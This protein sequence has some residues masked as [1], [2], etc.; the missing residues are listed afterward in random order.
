MSNPRFIYL[1]GF[2][3]SPQSQKASIFKAKFKEM[4]IDLLIPDLETGDF[5]FITIS[6]QMKVIEETIKEVKGGS[7]VVIG[8]SMGGYL[9]ILASQIYSE[10]KGLY[11]M[12]PGLSFLSRWRQ[13]LLGQN[14]K[15]NDFPHLIRVFHY[16]YNKEIELDKGLF[17]DAL[18]WEQISID[19]K[20]PIRIVHGKKDETVP[21]K[22]SREFTINRP[23]VS[24]KE[25]DSD[26]SLL[27]HISWIVEDCIQFFHQNNFLK[28]DA[29]NKNC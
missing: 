26:H 18:Q 24:L 4:G 27:S 11:L 17:E 12:C 3:S 5:K 14:P 15:I 8:S 22:V 1:H 2:A 13:K 23:W 10:V 19:K 6:K 16:R 25:L 9:A 28:N 7:V 29:K 20:L 21:I